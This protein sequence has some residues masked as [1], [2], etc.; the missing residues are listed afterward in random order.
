MFGKIK[1][2]W[3]TYGFEIAIGVC[4]LFLLIVWLFRLGKKGTWNKYSF[5]RGGKRDYEMMNNA[6]KPK[7]DSKGE[8]ECRR[9]LEKIF[10]KPFPKVRPDFLRNT[11]VSD[12]NLEI[13]CYNPELKIGCEYQG[14][15]HYKYIPFFHRNKEAFHN[16][17]YRDY[18][19][20]DMCEKN[21]VFLIE[22]PYTVKVDDIEDYIRKE[23]GKM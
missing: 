18:M 16:Q 21:G 12:M 10:G 20:R 3:N 9:V 6:P 5:T 1:E 23:L 4:I 17:K 15:Q 14:A 7:T 22:V 19:K 2:I 8:V 11:I 13:D